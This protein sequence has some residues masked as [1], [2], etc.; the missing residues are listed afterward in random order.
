MN[1][2]EMNAL[3]ALTFDEL[4]DRLHREGGSYARIALEHDGLG[5]VTKDRLRLAI[6]D[7][8]LDREARTDPS[9]VATPPP[10]DPGR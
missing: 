7:L 2:H 6:I 9:G 4:I 8:I 1:L 5:A 10:S 3:R